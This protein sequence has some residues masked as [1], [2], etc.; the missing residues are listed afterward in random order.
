MAQKTLNRIKDVLEEQQNTQQ[1][2]ADKVDKKRESINALVNNRTQPSLHFLYDIAAA[3][4][5]PAYTLIADYN[6]ETA[7]ADIA[8]SMLSSY[9]QEEE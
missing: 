8:R 7:R 1:W 2:L 6:P 5:V 3:L 9:I 4:K